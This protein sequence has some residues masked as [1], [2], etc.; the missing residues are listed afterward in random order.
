MLHK[1]FRK[2]FPCIRLYFLE[3]KEIKFNFTCYRY[4]RQSVRFGFKPFIHPFIHPLM[5]CY[6]FFCPFFVDV[7]NWVK[8]TITEIDCHFNEWYSL[9]RINFK[10]KLNLSDYIWSWNIGLLI[11]LY[12]QL[13]RIIQRQQL[14]NIVNYNI[15][16][17]FHHNEMKKQIENKTK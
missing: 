15:N 16:K 8:L 14:Y 17:S 11:K 5:P 2:L 10:L 12:P 9:R 13:D 6:V 7:I 4:L 1:Y 3:A